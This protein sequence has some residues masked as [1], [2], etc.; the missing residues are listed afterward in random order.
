MFHRCQG[1]SLPG[2]R[3]GAYGL[4]QILQQRHGSQTSGV[5]GGVSTA[6]SRTIAG[7]VYPLDR[8]STV[9][10][11]IQHPLLRRFMKAHTATSEVG[12]LGFRAQVIAKGDCIAVDLQVFAVCSAHSYGANACARFAHQL[13][14]L[15]TQTHRN[16][17][18]KE[19]GK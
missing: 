19:F 11:G 17:R 14:R 13:L 12:Q 6:D 7:G 5:F 9:F 15:D 18:Q 8:G 16:T 4:P 2:Q 3:L 10:I 1:T